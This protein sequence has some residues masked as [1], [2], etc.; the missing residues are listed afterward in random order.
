MCWLPG[1]VWFRELVGQGREVG[2]GEGGHG[3]WGLGHLSVVRALAPREEGGG[4][5]GH[6]R[7]QGC[8]PGRGAEGLAEVEAGGLTSRMHGTVTSMISSEPINS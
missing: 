5:S 4:H 6:T 8:I 7:V 1:S 2:T 3:G